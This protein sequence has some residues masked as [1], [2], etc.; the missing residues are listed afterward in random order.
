MIFEYPLDQLVQKIRRE[1]LMD[2]G[3][4]KSMSK[5]LI[6]KLSKFNCDKKH[7]STNHNVIP[8]P[9]VIPQNI[10]VKVL[11]ENICLFMGAAMTSWTIKVIWFCITS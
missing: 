6:I 5:R 8:D 2:I 11:D 10:G 7:I 4:R 3:T 9:I 1:E